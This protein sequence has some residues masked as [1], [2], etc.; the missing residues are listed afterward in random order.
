MKKITLLAAVLGASYFANAQVG[1]GIPTPVSSTQLDVTANDKGI[2]IPRVPLTAINEF[3]PIVGTQTESL[4]VYNSNGADI[5]TGFYYWVDSKWNRIVGKAELDQVI[6]N[7]G[8]NITNLEADVKNIQT[9]INY[10][11]P[12]NPS[13]DATTPETHTTVVYKD[14][15]F[16]TVTYDATTQT[17]T[18]QE[19]NFEDMVNGFE[20]KTFM[21]EVLNAEGKVIGMIYFSEQTIID[22]LAADAANTIANIPN[23]APGAM[24]IKVKDIVVN[25]IQEI[26][27]S[28]TNITITTTEGDR[29]FTTVEEYLQ[30]ITQFSNGNVIYTE[31]ADPANA[32]QTIWVFQYWDEATNTYKT[33]DIQGLVEAAETN[34]TIVSYNN[35]QYYLSEAYIKAGGETNPANWTAVPAGAIHVDVV[36]GVINNIQE[37]LESPTNL[38]INTIE[39]SRTFTTVEEYIQYIS[40]YS[41]G[42]VVY[43]EIDDPANAGQKIWVF[44]YW[45]EATNTYK[46]INIKDLVEAAETNTTIV[47]Y[48]NKQYYL[49]EAYIKAGGETDPANWTAVPAGAIHLDVVGAVINNIQEILESPTNITITTTEG[50]K[51]FTTVEEYL[52]YISQYSDGNVVYR[53]IDDPANAGQKIWVFQYWDEA[54]NT[55]KTID[56]QGLV[57][58]AETNTTI[59]TYNNKQ[60]YLSEAYIKAGGETDPA[61]WTAVPAGAIHVDVVGGVINNIQ[62]IL[63]SPTNITITTT[64]GDKTFTTVEEY[65]QY[66]SQYSDG[67]VVYR[68]IDDPANAGQ[69]IWVFQY[70]DEATNT[71]KTIDIQGLVE[72]AETNTTIVTYNNKQYYLS[73]AYIKA[74]GE[75]DPANWTAVPTGAIHV[76]VVGG[77]INNIQEILESPTNITITT[78]EG[79]KTFTTVEEYLQYISQ[80]S[81]GNV[82]YREIDDPAN[83][84]QKIWVFQYWDEASESYKTIDIKDLVA[85]TETKTQIKRTEVLVDGTLPT[86]GEV[87]TAPVAGDVKKGEIFYEYNAEGG[88]VDYINMTEDILNSI[89]NNEEIKNAITN[90]L[91]LG[92]NVYFGDHDNDDN[93]PAVFYQVITKLD[94]TKENKEIELPASFLVNLINKYKDIVKQAL[95]DTI[96]NEGDTVFTGNVYNGYKVY[97]GK[98]TTTIQVYSAVATPVSFGSLAGDKQIRQVL[99]IKLLNAAG[100]IVTEST[101]DVTVETGTTVKFNIGVGNQYMMLPVGAYEV[102]VEYASNEQVQP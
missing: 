38:T 59:V 33:I 92:G 44:Q 86:F 57:E 79:D 17:Y 23:N 63:E 75:T 34:T 2:L 1:I 12:S 46:T 37:I 4:L 16:Y 71:Y 49:S 42:N 95:G 78:T 48:N 11:L 31:I 3:K 74:G 98:G 21:K 99:G 47:V 10:I 89:N 88:N 62:E 13:N 64:E 22:W 18:T 9:V 20:T 83:A 82:V 54:T 84:G 50:D 56:I 8:D 14:G 27:E 39:G 73:E 55:Y 26:L 30:Y 6:E 97:L 25:N 36:G 81:D 60:Y 51:T 87:R 52:Q 93:T 29:T 41:D 19:I 61:N 7:L 76:D 40:Q 96:I 100:H 45:D 43:R 70:W 85:Q 15:K 102:V 28:P 53:E 35:K 32:G 77:V 101:T 58:A 80:Y 91:N 94:G 24:P 69:K 68:E 5:P 67:N 72:A 66:I 65:L 90:V